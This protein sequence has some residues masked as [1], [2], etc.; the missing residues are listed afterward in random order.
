MDLALNNLQRLICHKTQQTKPNLYECYQSKSVWKMFENHSTKCH[1]SVKILDV[2]SKLNILDK[3]Y[4]HLDRSPR[5]RPWNWKE[6]WFQNFWKPLF[7]PQ[8]KYWMCLYKIFLINFI[9]IYRGGTRDFFL[10]Y[11]GGWW[12]FISIYMGVHKIEPVI[13][14]GVPAIKKKSLKTSELEDMTFYDNL[15]QRMYSPFLKLQKRMIRSYQE[16]TKAELLPF[17][18]TRLKLIIIW[19]IQ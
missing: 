2:I 19:T 11:I 13:E 1:Y 15:K 3:F 7:I 18:V 17:R 4:F 5:D 14:K 8:W 12:D 9:S 6:S 10:F 16:L